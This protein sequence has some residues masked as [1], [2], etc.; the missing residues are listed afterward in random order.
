MPKSSDLFVDTAGWA[1][2]LND[3]EQLHPVVVA[4]V[5]RRAR[6]RQR[7][8][9]TNYV[10]AELVS[11]LSSRYHLSRQRVITVINEV[12][13]DATVE[14]VYIDQSLDD[15]AWRRLEARSDKEWSLVDA[16]CF[17]VMKRFGMTQALTTDHHFA[18]AGFI[19]VPVL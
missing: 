9:T 15:E 4:F 16:S 5:Q 8:I 19:R 3:R 6:R 7:L 1:N 14:V 13:K 10:V 17:V 18:Q 2:Y 11:L 12:K